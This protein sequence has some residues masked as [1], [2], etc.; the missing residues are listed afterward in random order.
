MP[1]I[2]N[3]VYVDG[4]RTPDPV[5]LADTCDLV[6]ARNGFGWIGLYRP[7]EDEL[8]AVAQEF[9]LH[10]LAVED[11][12]EGHQRPK[13]ERYGPDRFVVLRPARYMD[14]EERVDFGEVD[15]FLGPD[16]ICVI[17]HAEAPDLKAV[18]TRL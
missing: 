18:R 10:P 15:V 9:S 11:A 12:M 5:G 14:A 17:R 4:R 16:F 6:R 1:I 7:S 2:D 13:I 8:R 3:A